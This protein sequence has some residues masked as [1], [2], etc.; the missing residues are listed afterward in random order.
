MN[1]D[2]ERDGERN[3]GKQ[4]ERGREFTSVCVCVFVCVCVLVCVCVRGRERMSQSLQ[5]V[6]LCLEET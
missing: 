1:N 4:T 6:L 5:S 2:T 3:W